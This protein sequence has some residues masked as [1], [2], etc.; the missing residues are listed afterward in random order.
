MRSGKSKPLWIFGE[1][2]R[3]LLLVQRRQACEYYR[4]LEFHNFPSLNC[5]HTRALQHVLRTLRVRGTV[6]GTSLG[7]CASPIACLPKQ[8]SRKKKREAH[9]LARTGHGHS[10]SI[11]NFQTTGTVYVLFCAKPKPEGNRF[12][13]P[14]R[15]FSCFL[16]EQS[17]QAT[18]QMFR[19]HLLV[20]PCVN[21]IS[22]SALVQTT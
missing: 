15:Q 10:T 8:L 3:F 7:Q 4:F 12:V 22:Y 13:H 9:V 1:S 21:H 14:C 19:A 5:Q 17:T 16:V 2:R 6:S 18:Q 20:C 11:E